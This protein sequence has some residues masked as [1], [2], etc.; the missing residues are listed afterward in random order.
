VDW[1]GPIY[2]RQTTSYYFDT[3]Y[4]EVDAAGGPVTF[5][6]N[7]GAVKQAVDSTTA[8][9]KVLKVTYPSVWYGQTR[10]VT[11]TYAIPAGPKATG[12]YRAL[13]AY[14]S[15]CAFGNV[16]TT[17]DSGS[18]NVVVPDGYNVVTTSG[19]SFSKSGDT[20][21]MQTFSDSDVESDTCVAAINSSALVKTTA[22]GGGASVTV[23]SWPED[24]TFASTVSGFVTTDVAKIQNLTGLPIAAGP[25]TIEETGPEA[26]GTTDS[27]G[28]ASTQR[29]A[30]GAAEPDVIQALGEA[31]YG[32]LFADPWMSA[33]L[34]TYA[35]QVAGTGDNAAC[36]KPS[37][38]PVLSS[39]QALAFGA[40]SSNR[41]TLTW[42][43]QAACYIF[44]QWANA[45]GPDRFKAAL[46]AAS[47]GENPYAASGT[48]G[49]TAAGQPITAKLLLDMIDERGMVPAGVTDLDQAQ[50]LLLT[51]GVISADDLKAR[52]AARATYHSLA[53]TAG[54]WQLPNVLRKDMA[55]WD[56]KDATTELGTVT[57]ILGLRDQAE[58]LV[59]G[60]K[61]DG[62]S[63]QKRFESAA[64]QADL[65]AV[66]ATM[67]AESDAAAKV[68][69][70]SQRNGAGRSILQSVG[71]LGTDTA[72]QLAQ[73]KTA[74]S[75]VKPSDAAAAAQSVIDSLDK[76]ND[77]GVLRVAILAVVL[78]VIL[79][80]VA[81]WLLRRRRRRLA[82]APSA[83]TGGVALA[84]PTEPVIATGMDAPEAPADEAP[85]VEP[86]ALDAPIGADPPAAPI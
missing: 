11:A 72:G 21:G 5:T 22:T 75:N 59:D 56:F 1:Y 33:G 29:I 37:G 50:N 31:A 42:Q 66:L 24:A 79:L 30:P 32:P 44:T 2:C 4:A 52:S 69:Q 12:D 51:Y 15:L 16:D 85:A 57:Q 13:K 46:V 41:A 38:T 48:A 53:K 10:V 18:V 73:A 47:K 76:S 20:N 68:A 6:S 80:A 83:P 62:S 63:I 77:Q 27:G 7:G 67:Q 65:N 17:V 26:V 45:I 60:L 14:A 49:G 36:T 54:T 71:L 28:N 23:E 34:A 84:L 78:L 70:A 86:P 74:L 58:K 40:N 64:S 81:A 35:E 61:L 25:Y 43:T 82:L 55:T 19:T 9:G 3:F 39:W 8:Q